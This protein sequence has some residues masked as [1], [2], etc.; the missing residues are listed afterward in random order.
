MTADN[1]IVEEYA[2]VFKGLGCLDSEYYITVYLSVRSIVQ[3]THKMLLNLHPKLKQLF[4][5]LKQHGVIIKHT[6]PT[7]WVNALL[8][9]EKKSGSLCVYRPSSA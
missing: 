9:V 5:D 6:E 3:N 8:M 2:D 4:D 1:H 7:D